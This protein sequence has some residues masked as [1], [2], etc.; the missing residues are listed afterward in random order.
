MK[1]RKRLLISFF[2]ILASVLADASVLCNTST[3]RD[4][5]TIRSRA[6]HEGPSFYTITLPQFSK[7]FERSL[8]NGFWLPELFT[9]FSRSRSSCLPRFLSGF[10][11]LVFNHTGELRDD[12]SIEAVEAIRQICLVLNKIKMDCTK[13]RQ[14]SA[15][16]AF[17]ACEAEISKFRIKDWELL[18]HFRDS[19]SYFLGTSLARVSVNLSEG[20]VCRSKHGPGTTVDGTTG[21][22]KYLHRQWSRRLQR[23]FP[24]DSNWFV[25]SNELLDDLGEEHSIGTDFISC[26][27]EDPVRVCFVPKTLKSPRVIAIEPVY[28]QYIQQGLMRELVANI[29]SPFRRTGGQINFSDQSIN[30]SLA[31]SSSISREFATIDLKEASDRVHASLVHKMLQPYPHLM[32]GVF[33]CRSKYAKLPS[34]RVIGLKKFASQGSALCFPFEAMVFY[35]ISI[36]AYMKAYGLPVRHHRVR[37]FAKRLYV[38]GDDLVVPTKEVE[39]VI[40]GLESAGLA[41][42]RGKTFQNSHFRESCGSDAFKGHLVTPVYIRNTLPERRTDSGSILSTIATANLFYQKGWWK[43]AAFLRMKTERICGVVPHVLSTSPVK[44]WYS[45]RGTYCIDRYNSDLH[46]FEVRGLVPAIKKK[47]DPLDG[48]RALAKFFTERTKDPFSIDSFAKS[49]QRGSGYTKSRW[50]SPG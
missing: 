50:A 43:T 44:G 46:R 10:T 27:D 17:S 36:A 3:S 2:E 47:V 18:E 8:E 19:S 30:G 7:C 5:I 12:S 11:S 9:G 4:L 34:G 32:R 41:V 45:F 37:A 14:R 16:L 23:S 20:R 21:N 40:R 38:Y 26:R 24:V 35:S 49:V 28:N 31:V 6:E 25:N 22:R 15:E 1:S 39:I 33:D 48:Y 13:E 42:N 29:E